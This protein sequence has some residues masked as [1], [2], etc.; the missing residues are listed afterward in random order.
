[1]Y[2]ETAR[3]Q[4]TLR[5]LEAPWDAEKKNYLD[6]DLFKMRYANSALQ[7]IKIVFKREALLWW[8][9]KYAR[10]AR[11]MQDMIMGIIVGT[12]FW[13][14]DDPQTV[15]GVIFQSVFFIS[16]GSM[17]KVAPQIDT[18][19]I[20]YKEQDANFYPT[21]A[22]V[23]ARALAG[24]PTSV[25][26][27][28]VYGSFIYWC[29]G[30]APSA[31]NY[32]VF[33]FLVLICAF[34]CG[35][36]F[37]IFS[38]TVKGRSSAQACMSLSL[39]VMVLFSG[40]TVQPDVIPPYYIWIYWSNLF[41]WIIRAIAINEYQSGLYDEVVYEDGTTKGE[42]I[43]ERFGFSTKGEAFGY[44][45]VWW[46]VLFCIGL[47]LV[48]NLGS[49]WC[50]NH[51]R[52]ATGG[53]L[54]SD[55]EDTDEKEGSSIADSQAVSLEVKG[56]TL[57]FKDVNY[58]A[59]ASTTNDKLHLLK[60][61]SGYF[62]AGQMTVLMGSSGAGK[63][64][65]MDVLSLRKA[66]GEVTGD[67]QVNGH[68]REPNSFRRMTGYVEQFDTQ[69][70]QLTVRE[71]VEFSAKMRLDES[72]PMETK[73][74][75]VDHVLKIIELDNIANLLVGDDTG[76]LSFEQKKRL[77]IAV[78]LASN[79]SCIF[80]D[81]P[82]SGL[83]ARAASI[84]MRSLRRIADSGV[85][86]VA[87]IHQPSVAIFNSFDSLLLLKRGGET[88]FF[89][90]LGNESYNL[91]EYL[92]SYP[93]T[94]PIKGGENPATWM[95]T[96]IGAGS[97]GSDDQFD[98]AHAYSHSILA[99]DC[100]EKIDTMNANSTED[101][102]ITFTS[103]YAVSKKTQSV[104]VYKR[105][106]TIYW[107][108]PGYNRVR[109]I[110][111]GIV[112]LLFGSVFA[113]QRV[114]QNEGDMNSRVTSIY[115]TVLFLGVNAMNTALPVFEMERN[116][117]YRHKASL[118]YDFRAILLAFTLV[119][120]LF[121]CLSSLMFTLL[122]YFT[123]G[124]AVSAA[125]HFLYLLFV[126]LGLGTFT[127]FGQG[128]M[129]MF[130]DSQTAQGFGSLFIGMSSIFAGILV[131]PQEIYQYWIWAYWLFPLHY[132]LEGIMTSQFKDDDTPIVASYG[133][134]FYGDV[135]KSECPDLVDNPNVLYDDIPAE[136]I[137]G[138]AEQWV[139]VSFG[140]MWVPEHIPYDILYL[141]GA[142]I[143]AKGI[144]WYGLRSKNY[145]AK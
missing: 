106:S 30:F 65:L 83:G 138:T 60:G 55:E 33:L 17:L 46:T 81:E 26:D 123:V 110:V 145:L 117:F 63:T 74:K 140:G 113:S 61:I 12:V 24:L 7:S 92:E 116:M 118:M 47:C 9:D 18:R 139:Y 10:V 100:I 43:L 109:L 6:S 50:L 88:V 76:G 82:T 25:Q 15:M 28:L 144:A 5:R 16:M 131:R 98:Y 62:A 4:D 2:V 93:A 136:C 73:L 36:M 132:V 119:E 48:S 122:W 126:T 137:T 107:R 103:K 108:C 8:R 129:A 49:V 53:S 57:T 84:V 89:G 68:P 1:M 112:A 21:W 31:A 56:A 96:A 115:I 19:G 52:F 58:I 87:T 41:A 38:A 80:C 45:W 39:I 66:S 142:I 13:K 135:L 44:E 111:S 102:K 94:A 101:D 71:T 99:T 20:F 78:E 120:I 29:S 75:F 34:T 32:F 134:A 37:S 54:G 86:V 67:I 35:L 70:P 128:F 85:A 64:T 79:P 141:C 23:L 104:E 125:N 143:V 133:S 77:S 59:T 105:L 114:P 51:I 95:L 90:D 127:F 124:F 14:I 27:S 121:I 69:S 97:A 22:F 91:I 72:I 3:G 42:A 130:R 11:F 40:S